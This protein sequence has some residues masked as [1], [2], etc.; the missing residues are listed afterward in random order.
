VSYITICVSNL[1]K[2]TRNLKLDID[3]GTRGEILSYVR[4]NVLVN[5]GKPGKT[6]PIAVQEFLRADSP[7]PKLP[8]IVPPPLFS[9]LRKYEVERK[10]RASM[11]R[12]FPDELVKSLPKVPVE[13]EE[14]HLMNGKI[15]DGW[16]EIICF[17]HLYAIGS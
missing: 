11:P 2:T 1:L 8:T 7:I 12:R 14:M 9:R 5:R 17:I 3:E 6:I 15:I 13:K 16:S 10:Q 4:E